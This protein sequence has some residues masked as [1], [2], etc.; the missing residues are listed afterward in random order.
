LGGLDSWQLRPEPKMFASSSESGA[1]G[2]AWAAATPTKNLA[3]V[4]IQNERLLELSE[5]QLPPAP[6]ITWYNPI[7]GD[8]RPAV[9]VV[10]QR[11]CQF[12]PPDSGD[13]LLLLKSG[14]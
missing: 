5:D 6:V 3:L 14:K 9:A 13:W 1:S 7:R 12:P 10:V 4:Y 2:R 8:T 11:S